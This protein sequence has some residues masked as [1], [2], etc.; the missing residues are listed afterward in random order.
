M[1]I[2]AGCFAI[3]PLW[4]YVPATTC[5]TTPSA[6]SSGSSC[7]WGCPGWGCSASSPC[8]SKYSCQNGV[9]QIPTS[10]TSSAI[11]T[12]TGCIWGCEGWDC[13]ASSPC[14][15]KLNCIDGIC[16]ES[17][18]AGSSTSLKPTT[19]TSS[20][21]KKTITSTPNS[22]KETSTSTPAK[23]ITTG[24]TTF[25]TTADAVIPTNT[26]PVQSADKAIAEAKSASSSASSYQ[27]DPTSY[28][29]AKDVENAISQAL[30]GI[31]T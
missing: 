11:P 14:Q 7:T 5:T 25:S 23:K 9:C 20:S 27:E 28:T 22:A 21:T 1:T 30:D 24:T 8:Q 12:L 4:N 31:C 6:T 13:S 17:T 26:S 18:L 19:S 2:S 10:T 3:S 16:R 15:G 29:K